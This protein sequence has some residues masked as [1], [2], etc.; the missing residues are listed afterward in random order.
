MLKVI[1]TPL[2][3]PTGGASPHL[4]K[5]GECECVFHIRGG[6]LSLPGEAYWGT[7]GDV[8]EVCWCNWPWV[9]CLI[10]VRKGDTLG[11]LLTYQ[12]RHRTQTGLGLTK[13]SPCSRFWVL[14]V[15]LWFFIFSFGL[16]VAPFSSSPHLLQETTGDSTVN[17]GLEQD[18][19]WWSTAAG[20]C[21]YDRVQST[22]PT[23]TALH[24][25]ILFWVKPCFF[26]FW[27]VNHFSKIDFST[28]AARW[29]GG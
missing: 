1:F 2:G 23:V 7:G 4:F 24:F 13:L 9:Y 15:C 18:R 11:R 27:H 5:T 16:Q 29:C 6:W 26:V 20:A 10:R 21:G 28:W 19:S 22:D 14:C 3:G 8:V 12:P 17:Q 25:V